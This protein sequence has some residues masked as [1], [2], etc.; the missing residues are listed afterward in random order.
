MSPDYILLSR[1]PSEIL[2]NDVAHF[3][4]YAFY[5]FHPSGT[6]GFDHLKIIFEE[7]F[8]I[9]PLC[10]LSPSTKHCVHH[11]VL[12]LPELPRTSN[13]DVKDKVSYLHKTADQA[14]Y[15]LRL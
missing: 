3:Y 1:F 6:P 4:Y 14:P 5:I 8:S 15:I 10:F 13:F 9:F 12:K 11:R 7:K 2:L